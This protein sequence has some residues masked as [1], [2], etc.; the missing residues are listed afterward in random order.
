MDHHCPWVGNCV[1]LYNHKHF[2]LFLLYAFLG[3]LQCSLSLFLGSDVRKMIDHIPY[4]LA[5][6]MSF[7][8]SISILALLCVHTYL[9]VNNS[10]TVESGALSDYN[11]FLMEAT[12]GC[13]ER[14]LK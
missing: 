12:G 8:F 11:P 13:L 5:T 1:G 14:Q 10:T 6:V 4:L 3:C 2:W 7:A 9:I